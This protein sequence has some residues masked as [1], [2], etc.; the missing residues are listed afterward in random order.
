MV[1]SSLK[2]R[3][4]S[5]PGRAVGAR[6][7]ERA[8]DRLRRQPAAEGPSAAAHAAPDASFADSSLAPWHGFK[9]VAWRSTRVFLRAEMSRG[10]RLGARPTLQERAACAPDRRPARERRG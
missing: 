2:M 9:T 6:R 4:L 3:F 7:R 5:R 8:A 10:A 1:S